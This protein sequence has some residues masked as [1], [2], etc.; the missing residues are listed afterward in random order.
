M[1][2]N[3][4]WLDKYAP[5]NPFPEEPCYDLHVHIGKRSMAGLYCWECGSTLCSEG[6]DGI[7]YDASTWLDE[8]PACGQ[9]ATGN[10]PRDKKGVT[11]CNS[12]TWTQMSHKKKLEWY[13]DEGCTYAA[14]R[15]E[16]GKTYTPQEFL[17]NALGIVV[18]ERQ[19]PRVFA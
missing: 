14:V 19:L 9:K 18:F 13:R 11:G 16:Y 5:K 3:F 7:P 17:E 1:G 4:Y 6:S 2:T 10:P 15:D 8:C 12:F